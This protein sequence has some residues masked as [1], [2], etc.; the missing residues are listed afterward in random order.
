[1]D[2]GTFLKIEDEGD[3]LLAAYK[4]KNKRK[5]PLEKHYLLMLLKQKGVF[6]DCLRIIAQQEK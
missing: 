3:P 6:V 1:M 2:E 4:H 5:A